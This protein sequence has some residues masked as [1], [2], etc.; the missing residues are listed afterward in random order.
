LQACKKGAAIAA[1]RGLSELVPG[2]LVQNLTSLASKSGA[3]SD[4][5]RSPLYLIGFTLLSIQQVI[6][7][8]RR[9]LLIKGLERSFL[10]VET[11]RAPGWRL[12]TGPLAADSAMPDRITRVVLFAPARDRAGKA[13]IGH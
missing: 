1:R 11:K 3:R 13:G 8:A 6:P 12:L 5:I 2:G 4:G 10:S 9:T 7:S